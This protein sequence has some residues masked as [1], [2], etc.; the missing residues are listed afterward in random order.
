M[1]TSP[2]RITI[3]LLALQHNLSRVRELV[4]QATRIM[5]IV[6]SDAYGHGL[7]HGQR[8]RIIGRICMNLTVA[9]ITAI[10]NSK[11]GDRVC[12]LG[13]R[14]GDIITADDVARWT[15]TISYEVLCSMGRRNTREYVYEEEA[16]QDP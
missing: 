3:D 7:I 1:S 14:K 10:K 13:K 11:R 6:T 8:A 9:D 12:F 4:G 5:G 16:G 2:N 15:D